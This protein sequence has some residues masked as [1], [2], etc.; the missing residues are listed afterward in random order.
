MPSLAAALPLFRLLMSI[1]IGVLK[2]DDVRVLDTSCLLRYVHKNCLF[3]VTSATE[4][5]SDLLIG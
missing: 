3:Q 4:V 5:G 1:G 2:G